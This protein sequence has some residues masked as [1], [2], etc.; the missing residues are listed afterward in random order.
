MGLV[1]N[2]FENGFRF[3]EIFFSFADRGH[4]GFLL[5]LG[6][7]EGE[8]DDDIPEKNCRLKVLDLFRFS[9]I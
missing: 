7:M 5:F 9:D 6:E 2:L 8:G 3:F 1:R 4:V